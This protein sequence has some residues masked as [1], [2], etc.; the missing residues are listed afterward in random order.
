MTRG[1][2][3][4]ALKKRAH[5]LALEKAGQLHVSVLRSMEVLYSISALRSARGDISREEFHR[6]VQQA[7]D[8]QPELQALEWIPRVP[9][10]EKTEYERQAM[11]DGLNDF[12]VTQIDPVGNLVRAEPRG[13]YF[14][15]Y[16]VE[17][18]Q[19]NAAALGLDLASQPQ[20]REA[21]VQATDNGSP[22][23][24]APIRLAQG[25]NNQAG[26]LVLLPVFAHLAP[27][28]VAERRRALAGFAV[29]VFRVNDLVRS[30]FD[31]LREK[32]IDACLFDGSASGELLYGQGLSGGET[33]P[34]E[35]G[36]RNWIME[37]AP[38][39]AFMAAQPHWQSWLVLACGLSFTFLISA[40][41]FGGWRRTVQI[42][43]ANQA[44]S[45]FLA[46]MSHEIRTPLNAILGYAQL[47]Q[48][49]LTLPPEQ[50][51]SVAGISTSGRHLLGLINEILDLSKIEAG[52]MDLNPVDFDLRMLAKELA[53]TFHPLCAQ[54]RISFRLDCG[55]AGLETPDRADGERDGTR[56]RGDEGKL[57]QVLI[58]LVGNAVKFTS[59]GE[60]ALRVSPE[61]DG[62]W[63]FEVYDTGL[64]IPSEEQLDI[65]KPFHQ[66]SGARHRGGT[67]LGLAIARRQVELL[68]G[69]LELKSERGIGSCFYFTIPLARSH[70]A[71]ELPRPRV[72]RLADGCHV[73]ALVV[74]D[75]RANREVLGG[76]L[77]A[78][79]CQVLLAANGEE[80][81]NLIRR[82]RLDIVF[83]DLLLPGLSG[84]ETA[85]KIAELGGLA[86][87]MVAH[88][89]SAL[90]I[91]R[92]E[93]LAAG[94]VDFIAKPFDAEQI[95]ECLER[96]LGV[97]FQ[98]EEMFE[99]V[100]PAS[101][102]KPVL[103]PE[104]LCARMMVAA[105][106]HSATALKNCLQEL[107]ALGP[108]AQPLAE[109][110][111]Q[112]MRSYDME[113]IQRLLTT[114]AQPEKSK[115]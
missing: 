60:V 83:L 90:A 57:R 91:H 111:R 29:A 86:P 70:A 80:A 74:D 17:P 1:W 69:R 76:L 44:K 59:A 49:D 42:A 72:A 11:A 95:Y 102:L 41:L 100:V 10:A 6:F 98:R 109:R 46:S 37:F 33:V 115:R 5:D 85:K 67:G 96:H 94:C 7:L 23:A 79:G 43:A 84:V 34:V 26:L 71:P 39:P 21:L 107:R 13:E 101:A 55:G 35:V 73:S 66:G 88:T 47:L 16:Y 62:R 87:K 112:L 51:D 36:G 14:P 54:K 12:H 68:G 52:Q 103:L 32:H 92:E 104:E 75:N 20:R 114:A 3:H 45:D 25:P 18:L 113:G 106:L 30:E 22:V 77:S 93:A 63:R 108:D 105:E 99:A 89:A 82:H 38:T 97:R 61:P 110:I 28:D 4:Q 58:N 27:A 53:A 31:G 64:G 78:V 65:F 48:R 15:V 8:R 2:E 40:Y 9:A 24:T 19:G 56:V 81:V 50:R